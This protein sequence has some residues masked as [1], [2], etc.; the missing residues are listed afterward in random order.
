MKAT[1]VLSSCGVYRY[2][3]RR[4][5]NPALPCLVFI[6]LNPST[7]TAA[8]TDATTRK[9]IDIATAKGFGS[10][11]IANLFSFRSTCP[12]TMKKSVPLTHLR[13]DRFLKRLARTNA[14][15]VAAWGTHGGFRGRAGHVTSCFP[16]LV[17]LGRTKYLFP[18]H[19]L[20]VPQPYTFHPYP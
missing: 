17:C 11:L 2:S 6:C 7:A 14:T 18:R 3:L 13:N 20:Y 8:I 4:K 1:A 5:W 10:I 12:S 9:C 16:Q 19:P 15:V